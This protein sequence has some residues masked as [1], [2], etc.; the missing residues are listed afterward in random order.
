MHKEQA[1][2]T[3]DMDSLS[4]GMI[5]LF[6]DFIGDVVQQYQPIDEYD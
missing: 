2:P 4:V 5:P 6:G 1:Y 3:S